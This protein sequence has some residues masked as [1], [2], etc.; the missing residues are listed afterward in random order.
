MDDP[1]HL[2]YWR[3]ERGR[4]RDRFWLTDRTYFPITPAKQGTSHGEETK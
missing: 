3:D 4:R 2:L 1:R